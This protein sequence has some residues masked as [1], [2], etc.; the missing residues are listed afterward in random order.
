VMSESKVGPFH[1]SGVSAASNKIKCCIEAGEVSTPS[2][3]FVPR[4]GTGA[5]ADLR[6][7]T[8]APWNC[9]FRGSGGSV[10]DRAIR[11]LPAL[12]EGAGRDAG[13]DVRAGRL[14]AEDQ[15]GDRGAVR[16]QLLGVVDQADQQ[17]ARRGTA[18]IRRAPADRRLSLHLIL[19][20]RY[21]K[22]R[23]AG[24]IVSQ[25]VLLAVA[26]DGDG[27]R[28]ILG[29]EHIAMKSHAARRRS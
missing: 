8:R 1:H 28:Q 17:D 7:R 29:V 21:E 16:A 3:R 13:R 15:G 25:A 5:C 4:S 12:G 22:V 9:G 18:C 20:A 11:A 10:L 14:G 24:V 23:E 2:A 26:F 27:R 19:Y 6:S